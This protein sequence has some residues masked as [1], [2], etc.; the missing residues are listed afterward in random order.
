MTLKVVGLSLALLS[1]GL[2]ATVVAEITS[3]Y[4]DETVLVYQ[5]EDILNR[6]LPFRTMLR[7]G[8]PVHGSQVSLACMGVVMRSGELI[9][10]LPR[11]KSCIPL[12]V[13]SA[14]RLS[15][16]LGYESIVGFEKDK[17]DLQQRLKQE[18]V[19]VMEPLAVSM[20]QGGDCVCPP[21]DPLPEQVFLDGFE[22]IL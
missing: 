4:I 12:S 17:P 13:L 5:A 21:P 22:D 6:R 10:F 8:A 3:K 20:P 7:S 16:E 1:L 15:Q 14:Y 11:S 19:V 9:A 18:P 2:P